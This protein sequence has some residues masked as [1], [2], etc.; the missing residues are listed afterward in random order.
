MEGV[1]NSSI[2]QGSTEP[3]HTVICGLEMARKEGG[4]GR[5]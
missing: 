1:R 3:L 5:E 4:G 2:L